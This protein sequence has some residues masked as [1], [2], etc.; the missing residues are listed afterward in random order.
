MEQPNIFLLDVDFIQVGFGLTTSLSAPAG[1]IDS[2]P[3]N[4]SSGECF[5]SCRTMPNE[6]PLCKITKTDGIR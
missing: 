2:R 5:P 3:N 6:D 1:S 4:G